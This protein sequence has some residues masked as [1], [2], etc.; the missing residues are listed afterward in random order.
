MNSN[1]IIIIIIYFRALLHSKH[2]EW[3]VIDIDIQ[4]KENQTIDTKQNH[5]NHNNGTS[6]PKYSRRS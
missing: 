1:I 4:T 5:T 3:Y 2:D 6:F